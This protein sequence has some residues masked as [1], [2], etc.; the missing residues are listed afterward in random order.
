VYYGGYVYL[1]VGNGIRVVDVGRPE[2]PTQVS[3]VPL[4]PS[5]SSL[6]AMDQILVAAVDPAGL[7]VLDLSKPGTPRSISQVS[8]EGG[9]SAVSGGGPYAFGGSSSANLATFDLSDPA[10]P[11]LAGQYSPPR[12]AAD[13][14]A[15]G[16]RAYGV[17]ARPFVGLAVCL[18]RPIAQPYVAG[19]LSLVPDSPGDAPNATDILLEAIGDHA[20]LLYYD[21]LVTVNAGDPSSPTIDDLLAVPGATSMAAGGNHLYL[22]GYGWNAGLRA[23]SLRDPSRPDVVYEREGHGD[24]QALAIAGQRLYV[25][26]REVTGQRAT[27]LFVYDIQRP[28]LPR[29]VGSLADIGTTVA[30]AATGT[31]VFQAHESHGVHVFDAWYPDRLVR[32]STIGLPGR[33]V[34]MTAHGDLLYVAEAVRPGNGSEPARGANQVN[35]FDVS[36]PSRVERVETIQADH[37]ID[38]LAVEGPMLHV[39]AAEGGLNVYAI[40]GAK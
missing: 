10:N 6:H 20:Y 16:P 33:I 30:L 40:A 25:A 14:A 13:V 24:G 12:A 29:L 27:T 23:V 5:V 18:R 21:A 11:G 1:S 19:Y 31:L 39:G 7:A 4:G 38:G 9:L 34:D 32:R 28:S 2:D 26:E 3:F 36:D 8:Y 17:F 22:T 37:Q 15:T 35:V